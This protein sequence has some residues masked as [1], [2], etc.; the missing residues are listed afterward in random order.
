ME[1]KCSLSFR[2]ISLHRPVLYGVGALLVMLFHTEM[3]LNGPLLPLKYIRIFSAVGVEIFVLLTIPGL[4]RSL[5]RDP[6]VWRFWKRRL[7]RILP[8]ALII[9]L[10]HYGPQAGG[11]AGL[12]W[13]LFMLSYWTGEAVHWFVPFILTI[14]L[15]Y[16]L[17]HRLIKDHRWA[18]WLLLALSVAA[19]GC[20][21][22]LPA[23]WVKVCGKAVSRLP[24]LFVS[25]LI[26]PAF[27]REEKIPLWTL[28]ALLAVSIAVMPLKSLIRI[29][30]FI[31]MVCYIPLSM[32]LVLLI[33][34]LCR[35]TARC[36]LGR[37]AYRCLAFVGNVSLE[38]YLTFEL[39][40]GWLYELPGVVAGETTLMRIELAAMPIALIMAVL[41]K[42][43]GQFLIDQFGKIRIPE[44]P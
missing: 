40:R 36:G 43:L 30:Y 3:P 32:F 6:N 4:Y 44:A 23:E 29:P 9:Y 19:S 38:F 17:L 5:E 7:S 24:I 26:T 22:I 13:R 27:H 20:L 10:L 42:H 8:T 41:L 28:P 11:G 16:P 21:G 1:K 12:L 31:R 15:F 18:L 34:L 35:Y 39:L 33:S 37:F 14:Y 25:C 2:D